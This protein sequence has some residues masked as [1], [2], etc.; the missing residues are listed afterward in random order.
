MLECEPLHDLKGHLKNLFEI[1]PEI[2][3]KKISLEVSE[4]LE[5]DLSK[6]KKTGADYRL[7]AMHLL[8]LLRRR[9]VHQ[10]IVKLLK[11]IVTVS[12]I[13]YATDDKRSPRQILRLY[14]STWLHHELCND[15]FPNPKSIPRTKLFASY[16]HALS[17]HAAQQYEIICMRSTNTEHEERLFGQA[18]KTALNATNRKPNS[19]IPNILLRLQAKQI[20]R[21]MYSTLQTAET[22]IQKE[23]QQLGLTQNTTVETDFVITRISS[24]QAHLQRLSRYLVCGEGIWWHRVDKGYEFHDGNHSPDFHVQG[25]DLLHFRHTTLKE[26]EEK[27]AKIWEQVLCESVTLPTPYIKLYDEDGKLT[28]YKYFDNLDHEPMD[29]TTTQTEKNDTVEEDT[30]TNANSTTAEI[31]N[32]ESDLSGPI[33]V[34]ETYSIQT[35]TEFCE[36]VIATNK[37]NEPNTTVTFYKTK[38]CTAVQKILGS[39]YTTGAIKRQLDELDTLRHCIRTNKRVPQ[40]TIANYEC[41]LAAVNEHVTARRTVLKKAVKDFE[42]SYYMSHHTLPDLHSNSDYRHLVKSYRSVCRLL[43]M[44]D[45]TV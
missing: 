16:L 36:D 45:N 28:G 18:K 40:R 24:W 19:I 10:H 15:L 38:L 11:T 12:E 26:L 2:L 13:L 44:W 6:E 8:A 39:E 43:E 4:V 5:L 30:L 1:L 32:T 42:N 27:I 3:D 9:T 33:G 14:N 21:D 41:L 37:E 22:R 20:K 17:N 23:A 31:P 25:P 7:A 29:T 35:A 34:D